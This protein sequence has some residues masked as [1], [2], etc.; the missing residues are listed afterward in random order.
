MANSYLNTRGIL[1][2]AGPIEKRS[3]ANADK[4]I[5]NKFIKS[6]SFCLYNYQDKRITRIYKI[7][8]ITSVNKRK[9]Q[10]YKICRIFGI[11]ERNEITNF[12]SEN[13][14]KMKLMEIRRFVN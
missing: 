14:F 6:H 3:V 1:R 11:N 8:W 12:K 10:D 9:L 13:K 2:S 7:K 5:N 4:R